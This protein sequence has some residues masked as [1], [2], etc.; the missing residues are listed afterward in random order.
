MRFEHKSVIITGG[1]G[2]IAKAYVMA[3][4]REGAKL[5]LPDIASAADVHFV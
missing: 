5:S 1:S 4:A 2:K 3:F